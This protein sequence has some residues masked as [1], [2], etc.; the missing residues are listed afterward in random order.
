MT[1]YAGGLANSGENF[2]AVWGYEDAQGNEFAIIGVRNAIR[3]YDVNDP[4]NPVQVYN[5]QDGQTTW[6]REFKTYRNYL[7]AVCDDCYQGLQTICMD[8]LAQNNFKRDLSVIRSAHNIYIDTANARLYLCG[9]SYLNKTPAYGIFIYSLDTPSNPTLIKFH[10]TGMYS[11]DVFVRNNICYASN[12]NA[13]TFIYDY[14][15]VNNIF[16]ISS[17]SVVPG[18]HHSLWLNDSST[19]MYGAMEIPLGLPMAT[20]KLLN[21]NMVYVDTFRARYPVGYLPNTAHNPHLVRNK[22]Y[23]SYYHDGVAI[24][25]VSNRSTP[26]LMANYDTYTSPGAYNNFY[27]AWGVYPFLKSGLVLVSDMQTG[28]YVLG[29]EQSM[30]S[31]NDIILQTPGA[32]II[33][34][35]RTG[36]AKITVDDALGVVINTSATIPSTDKITLKDEDFRSD[37]GIKLRSVGG[38]YYK[39]ELSSGNLTATPTS[40]GLGIS[41]TGD[42]VFETYNRGPLLKDASNNWQRVRISP[43]GGLDL[44]KMY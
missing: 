42:L 37:T 24:F 14:N 15:D 5:Y 33:L 38:N 7:Y 18:Y 29:L 31:P 17:S 12:G 4:R 2:A 20:Y 8:S 3:I 11:H 16:T 36:Q 25:D 22:L 39:L 21:N 35:T 30:N 34:K 43:A 9:A 23:V 32:G 44:F 13:G 1:K 28:L 26:R 27:G 10:N 41:I 6:W 40:P 19:Y